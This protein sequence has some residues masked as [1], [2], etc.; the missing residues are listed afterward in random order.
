MRIMY[1][2]LYVVV[3]SVFIYHRAIMGGKVEQVNDSCHLDEKR[4]HHTYPIGK[5]G[6]RER[7]YTDL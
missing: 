5:T 3:Y 7:Y 4:I 6:T 2:F 1:T